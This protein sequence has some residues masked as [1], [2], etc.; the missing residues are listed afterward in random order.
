MPHK[1]KPQHDTPLCA[2]K[3]GSKARFTQNGDPSELHSSRFQRDIVQDTKEVEPE[4]EVVTLNFYSD[5]T[6]VD[7]L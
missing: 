1:N 2:D 3:D 5:K 4:V 7:N 6:A